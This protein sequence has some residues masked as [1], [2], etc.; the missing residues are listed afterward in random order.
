[1]ERYVVTYQAAEQSKTGGTKE[2]TKK[3]IAEAR[4]KVKPSPEL[5][6][7]PLVPDPDPLPEARKLVDDL[8]PKPIEPDTLP[9]LERTPFHTIA[10]LGTFVYR[11][12][13]K[14]TGKAT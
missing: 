12:T 14:A 6:K 13:D 11:V 8:F 9:K 4:A 2:K 5:E 3:L 7:A 10:E 1:A